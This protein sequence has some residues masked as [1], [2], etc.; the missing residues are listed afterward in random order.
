MLSLEHLGPSLGSDCTL[1]SDQLREELRSPQLVHQLID[2]RYGVPILQ[3]LLVQGPVVNA[4]LQ[5]T[6]LLLHQ[7]HRRSKRTRARSNVPK[8]Q[9]LLDSPLNLILIG[10]GVPIGGGDH[11]LYALL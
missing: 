7:H 3:G 2:H 9:K 10:L 4:H 11:S 8:S 1:T 6:I 5:C